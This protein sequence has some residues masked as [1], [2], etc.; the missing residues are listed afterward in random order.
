MKLTKTKLKQIIREEIQKLNEAG[1][2]L[3]TKWDKVMKKEQKL[4]EMIKKMI[5][6]AKYETD[7]KSQKQ[8]RKSLDTIVKKIQSRWGGKS[9]RLSEPS[10]ELFD[11]FPIYRQT[12]QKFGLDRFLNTK[13]V[14]TD[15]SK[16]PVK[17]VIVGGFRM[18][19]D[20]PNKILSAFNSFDITYSDGWSNARS[21][22]DYQIKDDATLNAFFKEME[23]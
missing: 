11:L 15:K 4:K 17:W 6:E 12:K 23:E 21:G 18:T 14:F 22:M 10:S 7:V 13:I 1:G 20:D 9:K 8:F 19:P 2:D 5:V 3:K 16:S